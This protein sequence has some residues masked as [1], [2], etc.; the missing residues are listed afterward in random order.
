[1]S[2]QAFPQQEP[3]AGQF[4]RVIEN[5]A[6]E[7]QNA[8]PDE[9]EIRR[10]VDLLYPGSG[11]V[12]MRVPRKIGTI[13]GYYDMANGG[14]AR[15]VFDAVTVSDMPHAA[16]IYTT[17][18][19]LNSGMPAG[20]ENRFIT[21][22]A[23]TTKDNEVTRY[24][25]I[26]ID[27]DPVRDSKV[28]ATDEEKS[29]AFKKAN[30]RRE[31]LRSQFGIQSI[32]A[33]S[34]NG[35]HQRI[36][37]DLPNT[38]E[39]VELVRRVLLAISARFTDDRV[40]FDTTVFNPARICKLYGTVARKGENTAERPHRLSRVLDVPANLQIVSRETLQKIAGEY[41]FVVP[42]S[43]PAL[44]NAALQAKIDDME[45]FLNHHGIEFT[46]KQNANSDMG[47]ILF[48]LQPC[49]F[50]ADHTGCLPRFLFRL[51]ECTVLIASTTDVSGTTGRNFATTLT[52]VTNT[53]SNALHRNSTMLNGLG[54][55]SPRRHSR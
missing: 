42:E 31:W 2:T 33:D 49:P 30:D 25:Q 24:T 9:N 15:L 48:I 47:G 14:R 11:I 54:P 26:L 53:S 8:V 5:A 40:V 19:E 23:E 10:A 35:A 51:R 36:P 39:N 27:A 4:N 12:E 43:S 6:V 44:E 34:G 13:S 7:R 18:Q 1:M 22:A 29:Y 21:R 52:Q 28:S 55:R 45:G 38:P 3:N 17:I 46:V 50:D 37:V 32:L 20:R 16:N 41:T